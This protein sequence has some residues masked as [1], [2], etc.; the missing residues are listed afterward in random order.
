MYYK[1]H[2]LEIG[3]LKADIAHAGMLAPDGRCKTLDSTADGYVRAE[4]CI[5]M[6]MESAEESL[7]Q[8]VAILRGT[9]VNQVCLLI[10]GALKCGLTRKCACRRV[11][12]GIL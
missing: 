4:T 9:A 1:K 6:L 10:S 8:C 2:E 11:V 5:M 7:S 3:S 12:R